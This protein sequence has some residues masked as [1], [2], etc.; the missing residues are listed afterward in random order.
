MTEELEQK[1]EEYIK[2][3]CDRWEADCLTVD[4]IV[5]C[6]LVEFATEAIKKLQEELNYAETHCLFHGDCPIQE[7]NVV[8]KEQ[9]EKMKNC[10]RE[11][12]ESMQPIKFEEDRQRAIAKAEAFLKE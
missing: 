4:E 7:E 11:L 9:V 2:K 12:I 8:A 3:N 10:L 5:K 6:S 1:A